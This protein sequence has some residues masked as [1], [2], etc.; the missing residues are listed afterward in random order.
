[1]FV[2]QVWAGVNTIWDTVPTKLSRAP[3][4]PL[5]VLIRDAMREQGIHSIDG[6]RGLA[7]RAKVSRN[8]IYAWEKGAYPRIGEVERIARVLQLPTWQLVRAWERHQTKTSAPAEAEAPAWAKAF[9]DA[10]VE[11]LGEMR[12]ALIDH[13]PVLRDAVRHAIEARLGP[14]PSAG[15]EAPTDSG[16][17]AR[18][19]NAA[20]GVPGGTP[21]QR[22][23]Q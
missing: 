4:S 9:Q 20:D 6:K 16:T 13:G 19:G 21:H 3:D 10:V 7:E 8:T 2:H 12:A 5:R 14:A 23:G 18:S 15:G 17:S 1:M 22:S 11:E